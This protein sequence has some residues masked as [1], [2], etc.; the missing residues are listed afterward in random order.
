LPWLRVAWCTF[1]KLLDED[2]IL[3][4]NVIQFAS[5]RIAPAALFPELDLHGE[6]AVD[7]TKDDILREV[8]IL[9]VEIVEGYLRVRS[10]NSKNAV[11]N[12]VRVIS[13]SCCLTWA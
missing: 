13:T 6:D 11:M 2:T 4:S 8:A 1:H 7:S 10:G 5:P 12:V 3:T 9:E